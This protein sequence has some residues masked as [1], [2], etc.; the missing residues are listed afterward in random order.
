MA[1]TREDE[2]PIL[3]DNPVIIGRYA[4]LGDF[5]VA[6]ETYPGDAD[7]TPVFR[8]LPDDRCQCP[9]W[10]TVVSGRLTMRFADHEESYGAGDAYYATPG[11]VPLVAAGTEIVEFSPTAALQ[12]T[13]AVVAANMA[14]MDGA[15]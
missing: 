10:G 4:D 13:M 6:F 7:G 5:T 12:Q 3:V 8:G 15:R 14:A 9:H 2:A 1:R 11:H